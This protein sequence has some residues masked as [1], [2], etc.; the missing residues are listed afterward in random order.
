MAKA[1]TTIRRATYSEQ[2]IREKEV[3]ELQQLL[4]EHKDAVQET[5]E[6][7]QHMQDRKI[8]PMLTA[9]FSEGDQ[10]MDIL[11]KTVDNPETARSVKNLLLMAGVLGTLNVQQLEPIVLKINQGIARVAEFEKV[12]NQSSYLTLLRALKDTE[13]RNAL[14]LSV[15]FLKG[16]GEDQDDKER[17][18]K[19]PEEQV[20]QDH[21][22]D[23]K[24]EAEEE[25]SKAYPPKL[26]TWKW[27]AAAAG[28]SL[29]TVTIA[30]GKK[31]LAENN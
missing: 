24:Y 3:L 27:A 12:E 6:I 20:D 10:V 15:A 9:L 29:L 7:I 17:T 4:V 28:L 2:E 31:A 16:M 26:N 1:T 18:T 19:R 11:A 25:E 8:L 21:Q 5:F 23:T 13:F 22:V 30:L 14:N